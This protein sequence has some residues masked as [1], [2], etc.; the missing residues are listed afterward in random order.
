MTALIYLLILI[1][2]I[3]FQSTLTPDFH[4]LVFFVPFFQFLLAAL[5]GHGLFRFLR[6]FKSL[7]KYSKTALVLLALSWLISSVLHYPGLVNQDTFI[8]QKTLSE[9]ALSDW[10]MIMYSLIVKLFF[11][12]DPSLFLFGLFMIY[13]LLCCIYKC[14]KLFQPT[15]WI[16]V[17]II[18]V[19]GNHPLLQA[20]TLYIVRDSLFALLVSLVIL[21][22]AEVYFKAKKLDLAFLIAVVTI[23]F[24]TSELRQE[25]KLYILAFPMLLF[26]LEKEYSSKKKWAAFGVLVLLSVYWNVSLESKK[27]TQTNQFYKLTGIIHPLNYIVYRNSPLI[28]PEAKE[29]INRVIDY[30]SLRSYNSISITPFHEGKYKLP[31]DD[32]TWDEFVATYENVVKENPGLFFEE[33]NDVILAA[34]SLRGI[35]F[36]FPNSFDAE[37][38]E[39]TYVK[40]KYNLK[41]G[42]LWKT[43]TDLHTRFLNLVYSFQTPYEFV[44]CFIFGSP[45]QV[46]IIFAILLGLA[47]NRAFYFFAAVSLGFCVT[48]LPAIYLLEPEPQLKYFSIL[49]YVPV[50][51]SL[52]LVGIIGR[53]DV[54]S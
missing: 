37:S 32:K 6:D 16:A 33:R 27:I 46:L 14:L 3:A 52:L 29:K 34:L 17:L 50:F 49:V 39:A 38:P 10:S 47:N 5:V 11:E 1:G 42:V 18:F 53:K 23:G 54:H 35:P 9:N 40:N 44:N 22:F 43:G 19:I 21:E 26:L 25:A 24:V 2:T 13:L 12:I 41:R 48:R 30:D 4:N 28:S 7:N 8:L 45:V 36:I 31:V 51:L 20:N 15:G